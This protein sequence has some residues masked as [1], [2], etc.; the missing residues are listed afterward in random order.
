MTPTL[1]AL[2]LTL[3]PQPGDQDLPALFKRFRTASDASAPLRVPKTPIRLYATDEANTKICFISDDAIYIF[4]DGR[5]TRPLYAK[6][7][8]VR[9][10]N[11]ITYRRNDAGGA[12]LIWTDDEQTLSIAG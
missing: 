1:L 2:A 7:F 4:A 10:V 9:S 6:A 5:V 3:L 12:F 11:R 8:S